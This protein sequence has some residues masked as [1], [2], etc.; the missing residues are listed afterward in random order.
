MEGREHEG[1]S[2]VCHCFLVLLFYREEWFGML[3]SWADSK[4]KSNLML[5]VFEPGKQAPNLCAL[6]LVAT[7][8]TPPVQQQQN[9]QNNYC[10][11]HSAVAGLL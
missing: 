6:L 1:G 11:L 10:L 2:M 5:S 3:Y 7:L 9:Y 4:K 8:P